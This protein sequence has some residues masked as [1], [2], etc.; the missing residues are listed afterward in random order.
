[1]ELVDPKL[2]NDMKKEEVMRMIE[3]ALLCL[4]PSPTLRPIMS[5]V[6]SM[7]EGRVCVSE[8]NPKGDQHKLE[9]PRTTQF[10]PSLGHNSSTESQSHICSSVHS[11]WLSSSATSSQDLYPIHLN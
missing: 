8:L 11:T 5:T 4:S 2:I 6:V 3:V 1:M 10:S 9:S 7:L